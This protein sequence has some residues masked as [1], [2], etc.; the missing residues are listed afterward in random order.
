MTVPSFPGRTSE[1]S[2][3]RPMNCMILS[4]DRPCDPQSASRADC[5]TGP[6]PANTASSRYRFSSAGSIRTRARP[7]A[8]RR[9]ATG[10]GS[11]VP[12]SEDEVA[13][14]GSATG[15]AISSA[16]AP[17]AGSL[18]ASHPRARS[19]RPR[20]AAATATTVVAAPAM[21]RSSA[22]AAVAM[23]ATTNRAAP[24]AHRIL[25]SIVLISTTSLARQPALPSPV[26]TPAPSAETTTGRAYLNASRCILPRCFL[27]AR[28]PQAGAG[29]AEAVTPRAWSGRGESLAR[30]RTGASQAR[31]SDS[32]IFSTALGTR[33]PGRSTGLGPR[34]IAPATQFGR[35][36]VMD[37]DFG[38]DENSDVDCSFGESTWPP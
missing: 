7:P 37:R 17:V 13:G 2:T 18:G 11:T 35:A 8:L 25:V 6:R 34:E 19:A 5:G 29:R 22:L 23:A 26:I 21:A 31:R 15:A 24:A 3:S 27:T 9:A 16:A 14:A 30:L 1:R 33:I 28:G 36:C 4:G 38:K 20:S 12:T 10:S 32:H